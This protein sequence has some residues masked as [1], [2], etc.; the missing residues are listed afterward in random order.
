MQLGMRYRER[1]L[2]ER[3][4]GSNILVAPVPTPLGVY[5]EYVDG[6]LVAEVPHNHT[7]LTPVPRFQRTWDQ[8]HPGPPY[9]TGGPFASIRV[10]YP[11]DM[12]KGIGT[13]FRIDGN[14]KYEY[15]GGFYN[16]DISRD[17]IPLST[18]ANMGWNAGQDH[19]LLPDPEADYGSQ[20]F[21]RLRPQ[22]SDGGLAVAVA[23]LRDVPQMLSTSAKGFH[24]IW[25]SMGGHQSSPFMQPKK[26]ADHFLNHEFG[27]VPF[28]SDVGKFADNFKHG[29][30]KIDQLAD[31]NNT[32]QKRERTLHKNT[33]GW[34]LEH[35]QENYSGCQPLGAYLNQV[36]PYTTFEVYSRLVDRVWAEG[37]FKFYRPELDKSLSSYN[38]NWPA[39]QRQMLL[40]GA[41]INPSVLWRATPWT[42]LIDWGLGVG[43]LIDNLEAI[44]LDGVVSKYLYLM[45]S[46]KRE[47]FSQ[48]SLHGSAGGVV[49][50][51]WDRGY[52]VKQRVEAS[53][54]FGFGLSFG[55]LSPMKVAILAALGISRH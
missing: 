37:S 23:E 22:L 43:K 29:K 51:R 42:W 4:E 52:T 10:A 9:L 6:T 54:P 32:W 30:M 24:E 18:L 39:M 36:F 19:S 44:G 21:D 49:N 17:P 50:L 1:Q 40:H 41:R 28:L 12:P 15:T 7:G 35:F 38:D 31:S 55:G 47:I 13:Y 2:D 25:K 27:W 33:T 11:R 34:N 20:V 8:K 14:R 53:N 48:H 46:T 16:P 3:Y 26:L 45:Q 5:R